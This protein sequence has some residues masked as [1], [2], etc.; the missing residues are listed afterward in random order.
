MSEQ[1]IIATPSKDGQ[2]HQAANVED[3]RNAEHIRR[4]PSIYIGDTGVKGLH[5]L[6]YEL[7]YNSVD[8]ALAGYCKSIQIKIQHDNSLSVSDDG[9]GIPVEILPKTQRSMLEVVLTTFGA[10]PSSTNPVTKPPR[11]FTVSAPSRLRH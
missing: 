6:V 2:E 3:F 9:R 4:R 8:E 11:V 5:Q 1:T 7:I 10:G